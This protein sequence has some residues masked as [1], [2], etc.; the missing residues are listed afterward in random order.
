MKKLRLIIIVACISVFTASA[1]MAQDY[2][3]IG[4]LDGVEAMVRYN[5]FGY[6][7]L[8]VA[9]IKFVNMNTYKVDVDWTPLLHCEGLPVK[10]GYGAPFTLKEKGSYQV[11]IWR[12]QA[13]GNG[14]LK[15]IEV[16]M[17]IKKEG[18]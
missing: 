11:T 9:Y 3:L 18:W 7:N 15:G 5:P 10:K 2:K 12:T 13:C 16:E 17:N 8:I 1:A 4:T 14:T 6:N